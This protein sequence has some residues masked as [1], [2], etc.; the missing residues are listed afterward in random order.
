MGKYD[1][2]WPQKQSK[3]ILEY[4]VD[5]K[6]TVIVS[7]KNIKWI[8]HLQYQNICIN[9]AS[10]WKDVAELSLMIVLINSIAI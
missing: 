6:K 1:I 9:Y 4:D 2:I 7:R 8:K 3:T 5:L 10:V